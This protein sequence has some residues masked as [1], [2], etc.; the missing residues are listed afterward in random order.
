MTS[1]IFFKTHTQPLPGIAKMVISLLVLLFLSVAQAQSLPGPIRQA[2]QT[3]NIPESAVGIW[4]QEIGHTTPLLV[5]NPDIPFNPASVTKLAA[6]FAALKELGPNYTWKTEFY[7]NAP[8]RNGILQGDLWIKGYGDPFLV[9]DEVWKMLGALQRRGIRRIEGDLV[10]DL[11][12]FDLPYEDPGAFD[13]QPY[14][15]YN[16]TPHALLMNFNTIT[17]EVEPDGTQVRVVTDPPLADLRIDNRLTLRDGNCEGFQNGISYHVVN[18]AGNRHIVLEGRYPRA[19]GRYRLVR[20][21]LEPEAYSNA[22]IRALWQQWGG[23][24]HGGWRID[25]WPNPRARPLLVHETR[26]LSEVIRMVNKF[27]NNVMTRQVALTLGASMYGAPATCDKASRAIIDT[28]QGFGIETTGMVVD[29]ASG[30]SRNNRITARQMAQI[31]WV[32]RESTFMP[33]F[34]SS[35]ALVGMDGTV[36]RRFQNGPQNGRMHLK[37]GSLNDVS[38]VAGYVHTASDKIALVVVMINHR[39]AH[40][41]IGR[42]VQNAV[43]AWTFDH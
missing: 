26:P 7:T 4:V 30:L 12:Y 31:L 25:T 28:L 13:N 27:S 43:L 40:W 22:L 19:C 36:R 16:Q 23:E 17:L 9:A 14:R 42:E 34:V 32:A 21:A 20:T 8:I 24:I 3:H 2:L 37:T 35:L 6:T 29:N 5:H 10:F 41:G 18:N 33:E 1:L 11:S 15:A 39:G 38:A